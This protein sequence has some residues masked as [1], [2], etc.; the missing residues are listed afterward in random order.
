MK[1]Y[2]GCGLTHAPEEFKA[3]VENF[4][5]L[6]RTIENVE[7]LCFLGVTD[8]TFRDVYVHDI[9]NCVRKCDLLIAIFDYPSTGLGWEV[10]TQVEDRRKPAIGLG[11]TMSHITR[12]VLDPDNPHY[13]FHRYESL[14]QDGFELVKSKIEAMIAEICRV[15]SPERAMQILGEDH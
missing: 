9:K 4:K 8:G 14:C 11:Q 6:L 5:D 3:E 7:V 13:Q 2:V 15:N 12:L 10:A 1:V